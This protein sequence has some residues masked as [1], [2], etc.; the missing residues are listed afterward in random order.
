MT[1]YGWDLSNHDWGRR[2]VNLSEARTAGI[3]FVTHKATE[4]N[5][6]RDPY[7]DDF[8]RQLAKVGR[9][10]RSR[11]YPVAGSYHVLNHGIDVAA[12]TDYWVQTV[13]DAYG[14]R[15]HPCWLWQ[16]DAEPLDGYKAPTKAEILAC[17]RR[18][19]QRYGI[20]ADRIVVYGPRWVYGDALTGIPYRLWASNYV[21]RGRAFRALYP[22][23][24]APQWAAYSGQTPLILQYTSGATIGQQPTCDANAVRVGSET[25]LAALFTPP[26][27]PPATQPDPIPNPI[28]GKELTLTPEDKAYLDAQFKAQRDQLAALF[29]DSK[30]KPHLLRTWLT[31][32]SGK[33]VDLP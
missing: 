33:K 2:S 28:N 10:I 14:W 27:K 6:Y 24:H 16:I 30:G 11:R 12:Q 32:L 26:A 19:E 7:F 22:G 18:L 21:N 20:P 3:S 29:S 5:W 4:G 15:A 9:I 17:G 8:A 1:V 31:K 13:S 25:A 23:D